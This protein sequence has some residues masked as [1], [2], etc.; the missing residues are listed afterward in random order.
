MCWK[1]RP[2]LC[3]SDQRGPGGL[4]GLKERYLLRPGRR[5]V[6]RFWIRL[7]SRLVWHPQALQPRRVPLT[8]A[9]SVCTSRGC[10]WGEMLSAEQVPGA[11]CQ[12]PAIQSRPQS[13]SDLTVFPQSACG[14]PICVETRATSPGVSCLLSFSHP[15]NHALCKSCQ[16]RHQ[17]HPQ[18]GPC[19]VPPRPPPWSRPWKL[20]SL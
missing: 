14:N 13:Y 5:E 12:G 9:L 4:V 2:Q 1:L 7:C 16:F 20:P 11:P 3:S 19:S 17:G 8:L 15:Y 18:C 10:Q 6:D